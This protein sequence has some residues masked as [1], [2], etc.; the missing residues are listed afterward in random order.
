M[1]TQNHSSSPEKK[2][3]SGKASFDFGEGSMGRVDWS[4][5]S[6]VTGN[7]F[8]RVWLVKQSL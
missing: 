8:F 7:L 4:P 3:P 1:G 6:Q 2:N 5:L